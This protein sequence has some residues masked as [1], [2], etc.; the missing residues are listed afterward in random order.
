MNNIRTA[1]ASDIPS[2]MRVL[3][4]ARAFIASYGS[5]QWQD[6]YPEL[7]VITSD[8]NASVGYVF[9]DGS[10]VHAYAAIIPG[11]EPIYDA[12]QGEWKVDSNEYVT[13]HRLACDH[14]CRGRGVGATLIGKAAEIA[15]ANKLPSLRA[16]THRLNRAMQGLLT[17]TG[18]VY[19]GDVNYVVKEGDPVRVCFEKVL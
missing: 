13:I 18:F 12:L 15:A 2:I 1:V 3:A 19:T 7:E 5:D 10:G 17:K 9:D 4:E 6:G 16:D 11:H 14:A 8:I